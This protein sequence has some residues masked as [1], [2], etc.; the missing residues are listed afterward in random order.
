MRRNWSKRCKTGEKGGINLAQQWNGNNHPEVRTELK[1]ALNP[2]QRVLINEDQQWKGKGIPGYLRV[3]YTLWYTPGYMRVL[4]PVY[5]PG[6]ERVTPVYTPGY[7]RVTLYT[8]VGLWGT[9][10]V[11]P[12][13]YEG[14]PMYTG[15]LWEVNPLIHRWVM[16]GYPLYTGGYERVIPLYTGGY[17][18][19][20]PLYTRGSRRDTPYI[21]PWV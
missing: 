1:P 12:W 13:V 17:E 7:E 8:P 2:L 11:H 20:I 6:Y 4:H 3:L 21:H 16:R 18:K 9:P 14:H 19:V 5:T 15:G 10:Y